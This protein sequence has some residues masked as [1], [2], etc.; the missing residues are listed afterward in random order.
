MNG[1]L[2]CCLGA[3]LTFG[4]ATRPLPPTGGD[5]DL[6]A[7]RDLATGSDFSRVVDLAHNDDLPLAPFDFAVGADMAVPAAALPCLTGG[8]VIYLDGD[9]GDFVHP[10]AETIQV[11]SWAP[12]GSNSPPVTFAADWDSTGFTENWSFQFST[13]QYGGQLTPGVYTN[14]A[15]FP[16][17]T[18]GQPGLSID[19][20]G[21]G[22]NTL[23]GSFQVVSVA[24]GPTGSNFTEFTATFE[25]HCEGA[26]PAL[27]GCIHYET[28]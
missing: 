15:R 13:E 28:P 24:L 6:G 27:R 8:S 25:Q 12:D 11:S 23:T 3:L 10:G 7:P 16:F 14:A 18:T 22:C 2:S 21:R 17:E 4:C 26:T 20:D 19:G 1:R 5:T 9:S